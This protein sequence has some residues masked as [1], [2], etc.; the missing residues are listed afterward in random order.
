VSAARKISV[1]TTRLPPNKF[2]T[3]R[4]CPKLLEGHPFYACCLFAPA[5]ASQNKPSMQVKCVHA[6]GFIGYP[7][8][9][10]VE[11]NHGANEKTVA[12]PERFGI[13][14]VT[15]GPSPEDVHDGS[16]PD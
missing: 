16:T 5:V 13:P 14:A 2:L 6:V 12:G 9:H 15:R 3:A 7:T 4:D 11:C 8:P 10:S 1:D